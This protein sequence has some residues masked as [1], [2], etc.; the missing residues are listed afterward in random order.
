ML[1]KDIQEKLNERK[2]KKNFRCFCAP[3]KEF[4]EKTF[5][6]FLAELKNKGI[7]ADAER[8]HFEFSGLFKWQSVSLAILVLVLISGSSIILADS[9]NVS[10]SHPLYGLKRISENIRLATSPKNNRIVISNQ[11]AQ[12]RMQEMQDINSRNLPKVKLTSVN[13]DFDQ[14]INISVSE[15]HNIQIQQGAQLKK[16]CAEVQTIIQNHQKIEALYSP[17]SDNDTQYLEDL[18]ISCGALINF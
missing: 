11:L 4:L 6:L 18:K 9:Q 17:D 16:L 13:N 12:R 10:I 3:K 14:E 7:V 8:S 15:L 2:C 1:F 5:F